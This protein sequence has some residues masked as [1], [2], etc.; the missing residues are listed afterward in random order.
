[1]N[2]FNR[3][4]P[5]GLFNEFFRSPLRLDDFRFLRFLIQS[6]NLRVNLFTRTTKNQY[7]VPDLPGF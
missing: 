3:A 6:K 5:Y 1:M 2:T 7:G 4:Y